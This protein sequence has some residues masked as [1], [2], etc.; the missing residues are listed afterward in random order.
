MNKSPPDVSNL[1]SEASSSIDDDAKLAQTQGGA[2]VEDF[3]IVLS[4]LTSIIADAPIFMEHSLGPAEWSLLKVL[5]SEPLS[6]AE[7]VRR[8]RL[9]RQRVGV[10]VKELEAKGFLAV[11]PLGE[12]DRRVRI[13]HVTPLGI[14]TL[15]E[16][17][18]RLG[19]LNLPG[20][21]K[22]LSGAVRQARLLLREL[23]REKRAGK[24]SRRAANK[25]RA[26]SE[27][28]Q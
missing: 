24:A 21:A 26:K 6:T 3:I 15:S 27:T 5:E 8:S 28:G 23:I 1:A 22:R 10:L 25:N 12:G 14:A 17:S 11:N 19:A 2:S 4:R 16:I 13:V 7:L 20:S 9:S 18:R